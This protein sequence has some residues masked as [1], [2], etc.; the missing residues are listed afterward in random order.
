MSFFWRC[1][2]VFY[3]Y[4]IAPTVATPNEEEQVRKAIAAN[5]F[6]AI[7]SGVLIRCDHSSCGTSTSLAPCRFV[8]AF[9]VAS[10]S[11]VPRRTMRAKTMLRFSLASLVVSQHRRGYLSHAYQV[12]F[13]V[14]CI[15]GVS[16][17]RVFCVGEPISAMNEGGTLRFQFGYA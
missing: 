6:M 17:F 9:V 16:Y 1:P 10:N 15:C 2:A 4:H 12:R 3:E 8:V 5:V 13:P 7:L 11:R 14:V